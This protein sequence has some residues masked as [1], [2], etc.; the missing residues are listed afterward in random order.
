MYS[1]K[2]L[3]RCPRCVGNGWKKALK[4]YKMSNDDFSSKGGHA[5]GVKKTSTNTHN[6]LDDATCE[7][8]ANATITKQT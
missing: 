7:T 3:A 6:Y 8:M 4:A 1:S 5:K 2:S